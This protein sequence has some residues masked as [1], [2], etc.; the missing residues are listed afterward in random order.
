MYP[1]HTP[2]NNCNGKLFIPFFYTW[3]F[4]FY[5]NFYYFSF[6]QSQIIDFKLFFFFLSKI[7]MTSLCIQIIL[8]KIIVMANFWF[9]FF[10][11]DFFFLTTIVIIFRSNK[12]KSLKSS[13]LFFL[14]EKYLMIQLITINFFLAYKKKE[15]SMSKCFSKS[16]HKKKSF[17][18]L[19]KKKQFQISCN[20]S[21][22]K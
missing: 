6:K 16:T 1:D 21:A 10:I 4:F 8:R 19:A 22:Q 9:L 15:I 14:S 20:C 11:H 17:T 2:K 7:L 12:V 3:F 18:K 5:Y 13:Y